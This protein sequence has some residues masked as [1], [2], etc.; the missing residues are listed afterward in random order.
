[1]KT[2]LKSFVLLL[3]VMNT[4]DAQLKTAEFP[5][6]TSPYLGQKPPGM[7]PELF[8][9]GIVSTG[10]HEHSSP[11]FTHDLKEMYWSTIIEENGKTVLRPTY[12]MKMV[13]G[14]WSKPEIPS[15]G[16]NFLCCE[17]PFITPDGKRLFFA[18][19]YTL[20]PS[21]FD[22]YY[23]DRVGDGWSAP[24]KMNE[25]INTT[26]NEY[27]PS[28]SE[29]GT[30]YFTGFNEKAK[31]KMGLFFSKLK[32]GEY[33]KPVLMEEKFNTLQIDWIP[34]IAPDESYIIFSSSREEYG[35]GDIYICFREKNGSWGNVINMGDKINTKAQE[36]FPNVS[37]DHKYLLFNTDIK[38]QG[39]DPKSAGNGN[40]DIYWVDAKV[41]EELRKIELEGK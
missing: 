7:T 36:R 25:A 21:N 5:K 34:Y 28:V 9:P 8:A 18:A 31:Y 39:A 24:I 38:I 26:N 29:N 41:I 20:P 23:V 22:L 35:N 27:S 32:N 15:F 19:S 33:E 4:S 14:V 13:D 30:L 12:Y 37:P 16:K 11:V 3:L 2:L 10:N 40:G 17:V 6:L 1:M